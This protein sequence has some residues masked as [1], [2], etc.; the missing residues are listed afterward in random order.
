MRDRWSNGSRDSADGRA[1][2]RRIVQ[3]KKDRVDSAVQTGGSQVWT[4]DNQCDRAVVGLS[5]VDKMDD[6]SN[7]G[8]LCRIKSRNFS[9]S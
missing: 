3:M 7:A 8:T 9:S 2:E 6:R 1:E 4:Q 5:S